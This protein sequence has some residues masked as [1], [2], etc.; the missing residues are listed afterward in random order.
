M[1]QA[2]LAAVLVLGAV[3]LGAG[4]DLLAG[5]Q[6]ATGTPVNYTVSQLREE[7]PLD[8]RVRV[9]GTVAKTVD[10]YEAESGNVYQQFYLSDGEERVK[11]FCS[12][13]AGRVNVSVDDRVR[14][15]GTFQEYYGQ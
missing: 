9:S 14:V 6:A 5:Q 10:D 11:V 13:A 12:T 1:K 2:G 4:G 8:T 7:R 15:E 3:V